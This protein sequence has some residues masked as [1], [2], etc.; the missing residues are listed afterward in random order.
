[1]LD[2]FGAEMPLAVRFFIAFLIVLGLI[3]TIVWAVRRL[4]GGRFAKSTLP[5]PPPVVRIRHTGEASSIFKVLFWIHQILLGLPSAFIGLDLITEGKETGIINAIGLLLAWI[6]GTLVW[7][8]AAIMHQR[9]VY[10][11]PPV[12]AAI[13]ENVARLEKMQEHKSAVNAVADEL[14]TPS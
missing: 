3:S 6:G 10:E 12:F 4:I 13:N 7:G 5:S 9:P 1:M 11:L 14:A 2:L 8:L